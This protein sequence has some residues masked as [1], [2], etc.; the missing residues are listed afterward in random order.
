M[1]ARE[2]LRIYLEQRRDL[3]E[4]ELVLDSMTVDEAMQAIGAFGRPAPSVSPAGREG[5]EETDSWRTVLAEASRS[6]PEPPPLPEPA[7][8]LVV[9]PQT[10]ELFNSDIMRLNSLKTIAAAV[11]SCTRCP[12]YKTANHGV[13]GEGNPK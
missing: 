5:S 13:P 8:G 4:S 6:G 10:E 2:K 9:G 11:E 1:D 3:G 7:Q 12:L